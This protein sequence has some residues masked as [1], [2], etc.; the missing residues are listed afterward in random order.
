MT[1]GTPDMGQLNVRLDAIVGRL[2]KLEV[3]VR[4]LVTSQTVK[5]EEFVLRDKRVRSG[6]DWRCKNTPRA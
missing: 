3:Q 5:A 6:P 2:E 4:R 1:T